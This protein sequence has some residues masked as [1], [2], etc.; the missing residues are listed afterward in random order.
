MANGTGRPVSVSR[1]ITAP[2]DELFELLVLPTT[3]PSI[4][5]SGM[6][7][8]AVTTAPITAVGDAFVMSMH[9]EEMGDYE[10]TNYVVAF[11]R[12]RRIGWEPVLSQASRQEDQAELGDRCHHVWAFELT[13]IDRATTEVTEIYDCSCSPE[14]LRKAVRE[15]DRWLESMTATLEKLNELCTDNVPQATNADRS[16]GTR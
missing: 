2:S 7:I 6:V 14:W 10:M 3:H 9:N 5:G 11:E 13:P 15:G 1:R 4:D 12:N 16:A 8:G